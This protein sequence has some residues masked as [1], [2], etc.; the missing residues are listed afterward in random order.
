MYFSNLVISY[1]ANQLHRRLQKKRWERFSL[2]PNTQ[3]SDCKTKESMDKIL[4]LNNPLNHF[5]FISTS[6]VIINFEN[7]NVFSM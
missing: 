6:L 2:K 7:Y 4:P 1:P 5:K 3:I